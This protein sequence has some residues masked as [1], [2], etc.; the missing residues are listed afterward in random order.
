MISTMITARRV[1][2]RSRNG[3]W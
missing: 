3:Q 1:E 2:S